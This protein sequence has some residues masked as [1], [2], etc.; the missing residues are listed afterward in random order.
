MHHMQ[1]IP[2]HATPGPSASQ[3]P[4]G[5][6]SAGGMGMWS[7]FTLPKAASTG[8][9]ARPGDVDSLAI[10]GSRQG[11]GA[12]AEWMSTSTPSRTENPEKMQGGA[13]S[14]ACCVFWL[15]VRQLFS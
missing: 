14:L 2:P 1:H 15:E 3:H 5:Q 9:C 13:L 11:G 12:L 7:L 10:T 8:A 4:D 6:G